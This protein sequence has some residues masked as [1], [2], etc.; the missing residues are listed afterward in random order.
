MTE[1]AHDRSRGDA[2]ETPPEHRA[3]RTRRELLQL[4]E[5]ADRPP[6]AREGDGDRRL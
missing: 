6:H 2:A 3:P 5:P 1:R 4:D